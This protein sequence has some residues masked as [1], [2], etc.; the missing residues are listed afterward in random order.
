MVE[1]EPWSNWICESALGRCDTQQEDGSDCFEIRKAS[2]SAS[3]GS[4]GRGE[5]IGQESNQ[6]YGSVLGRCDTQPENGSGCF[7]IREAPFSLPVASVVEQERETTT[8]RRDG[9]MDDAIERCGTR[10]EDGSNCFGMCEAPFCALVPMRRVS[11]RAGHIRLFSVVEE[12]RKGTL[13]VAELRGARMQ[14]GVETSRQPLF[15]ME[16]LSC[17]DLPRNGSGV[18]VAVRFTHS[19]WKLGLVLG[20]TTDAMWFLL[21]RGQMRDGDPDFFGWKKEREGNNQMKSLLG[22]FELLVVKEEDFRRKHFKRTEKRS[23]EFVFLNYLN[24]APQWKTDRK[25]LTTN[26]TDNC[27]QFSPC[28]WRQKN[29]VVSK[30]QDGRLV[31]LQVQVILTS[32]LPVH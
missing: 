10:H 8:E 26:P 25:E 3:V 12:D 27:F 32:Q 4:A 7:Q 19:G 23:T 5:A 17:D 11:W 21:W 18:A 6:N 1:E 31:L 30:W 14:L 9:V 28:G 16:N 13:K 29:S 20:F 15:M 24:R 22:S 2:L